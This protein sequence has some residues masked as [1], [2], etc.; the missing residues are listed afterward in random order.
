MRAEYKALLE[1]GIAFGKRFKLAP[2]NGFFPSK[3][4]ME[5]ITT[6]MVWLGNQ[7]SCSRR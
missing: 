1:A 7:N 6:D 2:G 3:E 4:Q 5:A